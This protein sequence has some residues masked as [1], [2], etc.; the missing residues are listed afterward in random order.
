MLDV[1]GIGVKSDVIWRE[2]WVCDREV[3]QVEKDQLQTRTQPL[4]EDPWIV[5]A[6]ANHKARRALS[7]NP[8]P[9]V[10]AFH[11]HDRRML[12]CPTRRA[13]HACPHSG[14]A[15]RAEARAVAPEC[16]AQAC[17]PGVHR[18]S[19]LPLTFLHS[20]P[21]AHAAA[22]EHERTWPCDAVSR[23]TASHGQ[24]RSCSPRRPRGPCGPLSPSRTPATRARWL[25]RQ[26]AVALPAAIVKCPG[27]SMG[28]TSACPPRP[29]RT[30]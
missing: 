15:C 28:T 24:V 17:V 25:L 19:S 4:R 26:V 23:R 29:R 18:E 6:G 30:Y 10:R 21:G 12:I 22:S 1:V 11:L 16:G 20:F 2:R 9:E 13:H 7:L 3:A 8:I 14:D 27:R 5:H